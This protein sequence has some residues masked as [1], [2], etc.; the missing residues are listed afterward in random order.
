MKVQGNHGG[1]FLCSLRCKNNGEKETRCV[2]RTFCAA[3]GLTDCDRKKSE[4]RVSAPCHGG[5]ARAR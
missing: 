4:H 1:R 3:E 2:S 5:V